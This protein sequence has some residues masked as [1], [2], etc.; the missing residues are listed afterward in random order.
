MAVRIRLASKSIKPEL[1]ESIKR[2][3]Q[4]ITEAAT[5]AAEQLAEDVQREG[6]ADIAAAGR[7]GGDWISGFTYTISGKTGVKTIV[8]HHSKPLWRVFQR[9][10]NIRGK[11]LLWIPVDPGGPRAKAFPGRLFQVKGRKKRDTPILMSD[12]G[13]VRYI[14][15][16]QVRIKRKFHLLK[17]IRDEAKKVRD[18][19]KER[20][21]S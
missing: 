18:L 7:F 16:K 12:D 20:M 14:G 17:I 8:F 11:P 6:R 3:Q 2:M 13:R 1:G 4:R 5:G 15:V 10:A 9:G 21:S 19:F